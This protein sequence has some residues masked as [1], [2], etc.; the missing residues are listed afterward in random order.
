[1]N[2]CTL[3]HFCFVENPAYV[4]VGLSNDAKMGDDSVIECVPEQGVVN[5]YASWTY[6]GPYS[7]S[8]QGIAQNFIQLREKSYADGVIHCKVERDP[9]T[10]V[11]GQRFDLINEKYH[12]LLATGSKADCN[13]RRFIL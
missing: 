2:Y 11:K 1:M 12:L 3:T 8:R 6:A 4:A 9:V 10:T 7:V 13:L 5:A